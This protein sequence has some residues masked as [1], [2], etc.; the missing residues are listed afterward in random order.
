MG[1]SPLDLSSYSPSNLI[2][3]MIYTLGILSLVNLLLGLI[4][5]SVDAADAKIAAAALETPAA[6]EAAAVVPEGRSL[7]L[8]NLVLGAIQRFEETYQ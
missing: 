5:D 3:T 1:V 7:G 6:E 4:P 8:A 2:T